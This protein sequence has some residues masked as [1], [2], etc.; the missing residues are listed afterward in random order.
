MEGKPTLP[1]IAALKN[2]TGEDHQLIRKSITTGGTQDLERVIRIVHD[3]GALAY[4]HQRAV[5]ETEAALSALS[6]LPESIYRQAL[7]DLARLAL[8]RIQ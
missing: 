4:C 6:P 3:S 8:H 2:T 1:L 7:I 5:E